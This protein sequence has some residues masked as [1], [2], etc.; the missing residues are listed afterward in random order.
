MHHNVPG[1]LD[2]KDFENAHA[3]NKTTD[4]YFKLRRYPSSYS[5]L[6]RRPRF[7][8]VEPREMPG[9]GEMGPWSSVVVLR[10][11]GR[12]MAWWGGIF[13]PIPSRQ[14]NNGRSN[15]ECLNSSLG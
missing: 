8:L 12:S 9:L 7:T 1:S 6:L 10:G 5:I 4:I 11:P 13:P 2:L 14:I 15:I 3:V